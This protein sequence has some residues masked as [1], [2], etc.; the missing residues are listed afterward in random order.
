MKKC[1]IIDG[2][3]NYSIIKNFYRF[4]EPNYNI[5]VLGSVLTQLNTKVTYYDS[6]DFLFKRKNYLNNY[7]LKKQIL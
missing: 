1:T 7:L 5:L 6:R 3:G 2:I 4:N